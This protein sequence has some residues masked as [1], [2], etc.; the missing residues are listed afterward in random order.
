[1]PTDVFTVDVEDYYQGESFSDL[2][3]RSHWEHYPSRLEANTRRLL[4]LCDE[5]GVRG[6]FFVIG[7]VARKFPALVREIVARGHEPGCHSLFHY[8]VYNLSRDEFREDTRQAKDAVE[9][10]AGQQVFGYRAP[11]F[12]ITRKALWAFEELAAQGFT[13]D[14]SVF[15]IRHDFYGI[16]DGPRRP[17]R[18]HTPSGDILEYPMSTFRLIG[19]I[20]YPVGGGGYLRMMPEWYTRLGLSRCRKEGVPVIVY[21]HPWELDPGQPRLPLSIKSRL[22]HYTNLD[23]THGRLKNVLLGGKYSSFRDSGLAERAQ[24]YSFAA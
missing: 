11:S 8:P 21:V 22:R 24:P 20:N 14:S 9:Q 5:C 13:Y 17:S 6:T 23:K 4:D 19:N 10:A 15:S 1:M 2:V 12:S 3:P 16:P 18:I 7:W